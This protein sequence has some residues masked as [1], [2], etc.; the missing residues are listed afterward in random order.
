[1][2]NENWFQEVTQPFEV[3]FTPKT[4]LPSLT[5]EINPGEEGLI[6][7]PIIANPPIADTE[8]QIQ[9]FF[10]LLHRVL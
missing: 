1:M 10:N 9:T 5:F 8:V 4:T 7:V 3:Y 6:S 2:I